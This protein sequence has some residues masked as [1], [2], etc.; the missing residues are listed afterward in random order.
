MT[1]QLIYTSAGTPNVTEDDLL[2]IV[3]SATRNNRA[4]GITGVLLF[5][6]GN[7]LQVLEGEKSVVKDA[8]QR[9]K[10]DSR[11]RD[12][13]ILI[14]R[15]IE[16]REFPDWSMGFNALTED[17]ASDFLFKLTGQSLSEALPKS[18]SLELQSVT[19]AFSQVSRI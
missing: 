11:H 19:S 7:I 13:M 14:E 6:D 4:V 18:P 8:F 3:K 5:F 12:P 1:Y 15:F 2:G 16:E 17:Q 10:K 9:I